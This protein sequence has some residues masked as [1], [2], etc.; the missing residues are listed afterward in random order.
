MAVF[1]LIHGGIQGG[2]AWKRVVPLLRA[3]GH[4]VYAPTLTGCGE[5]VHLATPQ[6]GLDTHILDVVN[7]LEYEDLSDV[8][9]VGHSYGGQVIT[10]VADRA[11]QRLLHLVYLDACY[12]QPGQSCLDQWPNDRATMDKHVQE[13]GDGWRFMPMAPQEFGV[14][15]EGDI[16]W[17]TAKDT[18]HPYKTFQDPLDFDLAAIQAIPRTYIQ[19]IE[20]QPPPVEPPAWT[21]G[22]RYHT[23]ATCHAANVT[24]PRELAALLLK[25][26][27]LATP[28]L[29][30]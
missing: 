11:P 12:P 29:D 28:K 30:Q 18:P 7:V 26:A 3:A 22:M 21:E 2:W 20:D 4:E 23:L 19:C 14:T 17:L 8:I 9:L 1:V 5:R 16:A 6:I 25:V 13:H 27:E 10:G 15:D 24:A